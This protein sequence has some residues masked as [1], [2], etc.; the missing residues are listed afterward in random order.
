MPNDRF[1]AAFS[2]DN[3]RA[4]QQISKALTVGH[5]LAVKLRKEAADAQ[6]HALLLEQSMWSPVAAVKRLSG[7]R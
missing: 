7:S 3:E 2:D 6:Q 4:I 5:A 1:S